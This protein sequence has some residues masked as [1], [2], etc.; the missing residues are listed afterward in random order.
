MHPPI[1]LRTFHALLG[2]LLL[3]IIGNHA[4]GQ[5]RTGWPDERKI[6]PF[7]F[8]AN[9]RMD[10]YLPVLQRLEG[11]GKE[12]SQRLKLKRSQEP[13]HLFLFATRGTYQRYMKLHFPKVPMR[14]ALYIK[15]GGPGMVFAYLSNDFEVDLRHE[16]THALLHTALPMV[17][18]WLDEGLAEY[19]ELPPARRE[20]E[21]VYRSKVQWNY[22]LGFAPNLGTLEKLCGT[23]Q[24]KEHHYRDSWAWVHYLLHGSSVAGRELE[25]Y[26]SDIAKRTPPGQ[27]RDRLKQRIP[28]VEDRL[29]NHM[30]NWQ[31]PRVANTDTASALTKAKKSVSQAGFHQP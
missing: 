13:I 22:R 26:L 8:H 10:N 25:N 23:A 15:N 4:Q 5:N 20:K 17:P 19:F 2:C 12:V 24:M 3:V 1:F 18:L 30:M 6:G 28:N 9:F 16:T 11:L 14:K 7:V 21:S 29:K 27:F 31:P